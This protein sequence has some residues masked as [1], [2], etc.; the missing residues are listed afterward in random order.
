MHYGVWKHVS[1]GIAIA[2]L[3]RLVAFRLLR[4]HAWCEVCHHDHHGSGVCPPFGTL[5]PNV[6]GIAVEFCLL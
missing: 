3:L 6:A 1:G 2:P 4:F 5:I